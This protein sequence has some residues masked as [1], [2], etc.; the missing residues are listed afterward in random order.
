MAKITLAK[1]GH[2]LKRP[3]QLISCDDFFGTNDWPTSNFFMSHR[4]T[5]TI[6]EACIKI[7]RHY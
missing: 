5:N 1:G 6:C 4:D 7:L 2:G 3:S